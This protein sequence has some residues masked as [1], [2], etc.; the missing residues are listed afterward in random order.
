MTFRNLLPPGLVIKKLCSTLKDRT[1][2]EF[3]LAVKFDIWQQTRMSSYRSL[4]LVA[5]VFLC[6]AST[7]RGEYAFRY[8]D[9]LGRP[10]SGFYAAINDAG[11]VAW[12]GGW[13]GINWIGVGDSTGRQRQILGAPGYYLNHFYTPPMINDFGHIAFVGISSSAESNAN[14]IFRTRPPQNIPVMIVDGS[15]LN[16][17]SYALGLS[18]VALENS[19]VITYNR[20][21][22]DVNHSSSYRTT[23][24][25]GT[26][27][28][29]EPLTPR[30]GSGNG[31]L[32]S[33]GTRITF[34]GNTV[35][36]SSH[37]MWGSDPPQ[38]WAN[39]ANTSGE[40]VFS[41]YSH[42]SVGLFLAY[43]AQSPPTIVAQ[44]T[45][46]TVAIG[47][48][49][50][51]SVGAGGAPVLRYQWQKD[52][53][54]I[55]GATN[56]T[57]VLS[58]VQTIDIT[59]YSVLVSNPYGSA[60]SVDAVLTVLETDLVAVGLAWNNTIGGVD[61]RYRVDNGALANGTT[62]KLFWASGTS[63]ANILSATPI[64][65]GNIP[66]GSSGV[67]TFN[68]PASSFGTP[69][70]GTTHLLLAVD[71][72]NVINNE[73]NE[74]NN[75]V[76]L[77]DVLVVPENSGVNME[78]L[79]SYTIDVIKASLR[80]AGEPRAVVT[81]TKRTIRSQAQAVYANILKKG[82]PSQKQLYAGNPAMAAALQAYEDALG[83]VPPPDFVGVMTASLEASATAGADLGS[84]SKHL[85]DFSQLQAVDISYSR[86]VNK[87]LFWSALLANP[88][89]SRRLSPFNSQDPAFHIEILQPQPLLPQ[90]VENEV[91]LEQLPNMGLFLTSIP[92][93]TDDS[94]TI[95]LASQQNGSASIDSLGCIPNAIP[96]PLENGFGIISGS[97]SNGHRVF[98]FTAEEGE[99]LTLGVDV[100]GFRQGSLH[101]DND[102]MIYLFN[103]TCALLASN[104][105]TD[106]FATEME[107][108]IQSFIIPSS[109]V[110]YVSI[111]TFENSPIFSDSS[112]LTGWQ[113]DGGSNVDFDLFVS[114]ASPRIRVKTIEG[115][116][117][118]VSWGYGGVLEEA[119]TLSGA[120]REIIGAVSP[121]IISGAVGQK[122]YR[123]RR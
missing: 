7:A 100:T 33:D 37:P 53:S 119:G 98:S 15:T 29:I 61:A 94:L 70:S 2:R 35:I 88:K 120:W 10:N 16:L 67:I 118:E 28:R 66:A 65:T 77:Q 40:I 56:S 11:Q 103:D 24:G 25:G 49:V 113:E 71:Y 99:I 14:A 62:A 50:T 115:G 12:W 19:G 26:L 54:P 78:I 89:I 97:V 90:L 105:D 46:Q 1:T 18:V 110:Y 114:V 83:V 106:V 101:Q 69:P 64:F 60:R 117:L 55:S 23:G 6:F 73:A 20:W 47:A 43:L 51:F 109:G 92:M 59:A 81:S 44:P 108:A 21:N 30:T 36:D 57:Y 79:S 39:C 96:I 13:M 22:A 72:G 32:A 87:K 93:N 76:A 95:A 41:A 84:I 27:V 112:E 17:P 31:S 86:I 122:F 107:S 8:L 116:K 3:T 74:N 75:S 45:G 38:L 42:G 5:T 9:S 52:V 4:Y 91:A 80:V 34:N 48:S 63:T 58:N 85:G 82:L 111:T 104:D 123:F 102:S 68:I 121:F